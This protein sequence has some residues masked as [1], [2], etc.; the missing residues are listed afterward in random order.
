MDI[1]ETKHGPEAAVCAVAAEFFGRYSAH[2]VD[3]MVDLCSVEASFTYVPIEYW[4]E[5]GTLRGRGSVRS[6]GKAVWTGLMRSFPDLWVRVETV[7]SNSQGDAIV[8]ACIGGTQA[9][10][11]GF[12]S[13]RGGRFEENHL[14][15]LHVGDDRLIDNI[16]AYWNGAGMN[17]QLG[18]IEID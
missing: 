8:Q 12:V 10:A 18:H 13:P 16:A 5:Q 1:P 6:V 17:R 15:V 11:W 4:S 2:D 9:R 14:F 7:D 3:G